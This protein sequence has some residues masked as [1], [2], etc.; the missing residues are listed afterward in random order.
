[1]MKKSILLIGHRATGKSTLGRALASHRNVR[2][3]DLD[4]HISA[5]QGSTASELVTA[6]ETAFRRMEIDALGALLAGDEPL[7]ISAGGGL[8]RVPTDVHVIWISR[9][10]W[11][12]SAIE[13]RVRLRPEMSAEAEVA[14]M[15]ETRESRYRRGAHVRLHIERDCDETEAAA[16]LALLADWLDGAISSPGARMSWMLPRDEKD[17]PR[18]IADVRLFGL[19]GVEIRSDRFPEIPELDV[20]WLASLRTEE[21]GYFARARSAKAFDCDTALLRH[22]DLTGLTPRPLILSTHPGDVYREYFDHLVSLPAWI[23]RSWPEWKDQ[24]MLKYAPRVKTWTELRYAYQLYKVY[25]KDGGRITFLPQGKQ[26]NWVRAMRM[27][28]GNQSNYLST[29]CEEYSQRPPGIDHFLPHLQQPS[30]DTFYGVLGQP[31]EQSYGDIL[32]RALSLHA[33]EGRAAYFKIPLGAAEIDNCLHLLPQ[34][35]FRGLSVTAPLKTAMVESNFVGCELDLPAGNTLAYIK[36]S[37]LLYDTDEKGMEAALQDIERDGFPPGPVGLF[38]GGGVSHA[39]ARALASRGW[40]P[41][42]QVSAREGWG[43]L[44]GE[45]FVLV[46][47]ASGGYGTNGAHPRARVWLDLRYRDVAR[48]PDGCERIYSGMT[49]FKRQAREQ[50]TLWGL[51]PVDSHPLL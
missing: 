35:G 2:H 11:E 30:A 44:A 12:E 42:Q 6:N 18:A 36:G 29:G 3:V 8:E 23:E 19:A 41:V 24:V 43:A 33:D 32:H 15:R 38:G 48:A 17:L 40:G 28:A 7:V 39:V 45:D 21:N 26:W 50:R 27:H 1:M 31:V 4:D 20:P 51:S 37:F 22:L 16:R 25:E 47:D 14:W 49:F 5:V 46:V 10:G 13:G 34:F 9:D